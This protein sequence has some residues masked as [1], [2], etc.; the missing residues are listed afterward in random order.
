[1]ST[2]CHHQWQVDDRKESEPMKSTTYA[3]QQAHVAGAAR[4]CGGFGRPWRHEDTVM[5]NGN[6]INGLAAFMK[7]TAAATKRT[8]RH[9]GTAST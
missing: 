4:S 2:I 5:V 6:A 8:A 9:L 1:L 3:T 7:S